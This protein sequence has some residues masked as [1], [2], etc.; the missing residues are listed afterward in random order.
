M[1]QLIPKAFIFDCDG[2]LVNSEEPG[3]EVIQKLAQSHG[4]SIELEEAL[5]RFTG[6]KMSEIVNWVSQHMKSPLPVDFH[7]HFT[8][9]VRYEQSKRFKEGLETIP[10]AKELLSWIHLPKGVATNGPMEKVELTLSLTGLRS[11][12]AE[13]VYSAYDIGHFKPSPQLFLHVAKALGVPARDCAV[14]EDSLTG[15]TAG[16]EAQMQVFSLAKPHHL[17]QA[18]HAKVT[19][20]ADLHALKDLLTQSHSFSR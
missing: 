14:V 6:L 10:G 2:T 20:I 7:E 15:I 16:L 1:S 5:D 3:I 4:V 9:Q 11:F 18:M 13:H 17:P 19:F 8:R 12:F